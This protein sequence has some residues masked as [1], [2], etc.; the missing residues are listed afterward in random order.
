M[1]GE[2]AESEPYLA[3]ALRV[4]ESRMGADSESTREAGNLL[5]AVKQAALQRERSDLDRVEK[6]AKRIGS[7]P[8]R[9]RELMARVGASGA[10]RALLDKS[11]ASNGVN[12]PATDDRTGSRGHLEVDEL[13]K[14]IQG[15]DKPTSKNKKK[16]NGK[17]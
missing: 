11:Q 13:V 16:T 9:A 10:S 4:Y 12:S 14:F 1:S 7:D 8:A 2:L 3:E 5:S 17:A 6:L 15:N